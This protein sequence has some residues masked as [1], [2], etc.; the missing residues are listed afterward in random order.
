MTIRSERVISIAL[1]LSAT[2]LAPISASADAAAA[3]GRESDASAI[4]AKRERFRAGMEKYRAG[5]FAEAIEIW[6]AI[7]AE[8]G[9][10]KGYRL[11]FNIARAY[12]QRA[13]TRTG[14][15][16]AITDTTKAGEHYA[17]YVN[18]TARRHEAGEALEPLIERQEVEAKER[19]GSIHLRGDARIVVKI[20]DEANERH[21]GFVVWVVPGPHV[22]TFHPGTRAQA[23]LRVTVATGQV[24]ELTPPAP[25]ESAAT[26]ARSAIR[27]ETREERPFHESWIYL[28]AGVTALAVIVPVIFYSN[29]WAIGEEYDA[30]S[31]P[32]E[33]TRLA[34]DYDT[35]RTNAYASIVLPSLAAATTLGLAAYWYLGKQTVRVPVQ[36]AITP[37]GGMIGAAAS[38]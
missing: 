33:R 10:E 14:S 9:P 35:A 21:A 32:I 22:V 28:S 19:L 38:F 29:A 15:P 27:F 1:F 2:T 6:E 13:T 16:A 34:A 20:D 31:E 37:S 36:A 24:A 8:L 3:S 30:T 11:A 4:E 12:E 26:T 7:Y 5:A 23:A 18:E 17:A 25:A